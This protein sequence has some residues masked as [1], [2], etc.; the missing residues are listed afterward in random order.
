MPRT[1]A[2]DSSFW[3]SGT[4]LLAGQSPG[5][6]LVTSGALPVE[7]FWLI[8]LT[9]AGDVAWTYSARWF[10]G[11]VVNRSQER[12]CAAG[13]EDWTWGPF[14]AAAGDVISAVLTVASSVTRLQMSLLM[15]DFG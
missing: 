8:Q 2:F 12:I 11:A 15:V 5:A 14:Q 7:G 9:G 6:V 3:V 10:T 1:D 4:L 13:N